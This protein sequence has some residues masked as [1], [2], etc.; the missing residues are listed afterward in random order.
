VSSQIGISA[1]AA[2]HYLT[3]DTIADLAP[4]MVISLA[5]ETPGA[6]VIESARTAAVLVCA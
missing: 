6:D 2:R 3:D 4:T 1:T 5:D